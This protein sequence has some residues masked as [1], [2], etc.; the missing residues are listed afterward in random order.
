M[1]TKEKNNWCFKKLKRQR[2]EKQIHADD[3]K[4]KLLI[5]KEKKIFENIFNKR[6]DKIEEL[7][8]K[9]DYDDLIFITESKNRKTN[10]SQKKGPADFLNETK[11]GEITIEQAKDSQEDFNNYLKTIRRG[12]KTKKQGNTLANINRLFNG[13]NDAIKFIEDYG[14]MILEAKKKSC[15]RTSNRNRT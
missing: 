9:V 5:P 11:K 6:L 13:R 10:F 3:Y 2:K 14:S 7:D 1:K 8:K 15:R 12:N 4:N